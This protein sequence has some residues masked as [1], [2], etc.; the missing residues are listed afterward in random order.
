MG[1]VK[2][3]TVNDQLLRLKYSDENNIRMFLR[4]WSGL[5]RLGEKGDTV[6][7]CILCDLKTVTGIDPQLW[8]KRRI[9]RV[10]FEMGRHKGV[11]TYHQFISIAYTLV[12]GYKQDEV[13][14]MLGIDQSGLSRHISSGIKEI[15]LALK[16][17]L[18]E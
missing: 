6:A 1:A 11:L 17:E 16:A 5:E 2:I 7:I 12:L 8:G 18:E 4:N 14:F 15:Q 3:D 9:N 13:A 10:R